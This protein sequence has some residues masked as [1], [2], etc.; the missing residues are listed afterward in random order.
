MEK[1]D[2]CTGEAEEWVFRKFALG[3]LIGSFADLLFKLARVV[4]GDGEKQKIPFGVKIL[5]HSSF[6]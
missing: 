5:L 1:V 2:E 6:Y 4:E 3:D